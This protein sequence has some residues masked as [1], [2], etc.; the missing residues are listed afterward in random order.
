MTKGSG[1]GFQRCRRNDMWRRWSAGQS[2][3]E[4]LFLRSADGNRTVYGGLQ[5]FQSD[6]HLRDYIYFSRVFSW[7]QWRGN[8]RESLDRME[9]T[10]RQAH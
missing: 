7:G 8:W 6:P 5:K 2:L 4:R 10:R 3:H 1:L 9:W